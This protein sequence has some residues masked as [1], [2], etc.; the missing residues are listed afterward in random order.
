MTGR[1]HV[2]ISCGDDGSQSYFPA[3]ATA[4]AAVAIATGAYTGGGGDP[5]AVDMICVS[6]RPAAVTP[7][8]SPQPPR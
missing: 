5:A 7:T 6:R 3:A 4:A 8:G 2:L 1:W